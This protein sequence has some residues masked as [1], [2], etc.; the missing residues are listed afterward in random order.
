MELIPAGDPDALLGDVGVIGEAGIKRV[1]DAEKGSD[2]ARAVE[3]GVAFAA[4]VLHTDLVTRGD[5]VGRRSGKGKVSVAVVVVKIGVGGSQ[6]GE[7]VDILAGN[8][9]RE[10]GIAHRPVDARLRGPVVV[11]AIAEIG[12][13]ARLAL[14]ASGE[15]LDHP[16]D[17]I[18]PVE[19]GGRTAQ[20]LDTIDQRDRKIFEGGGAGSRGIDPDAVDQDQ[21][22][23]GIG[24]AHEDAG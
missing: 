24:T 4:E 5:L 15:D 23:V 2:V 13:K 17:R 21:H 1:G 8:G 3:A 19:A 22:V 12:K 11:G 20:D 16:A 9:Q 7:A 18:L 10:P 6:R 14:A